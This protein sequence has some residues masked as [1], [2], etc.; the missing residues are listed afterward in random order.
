V[1]N[2][3]G[4]DFRM[5]PDTGA[6]EPVSGLT[7]QG[8]VRDDFGNWFGC[9]NSHL[10]WHY[11]LAD[12]YVRR[13]PFVAAPSPAVPVPRDRD[14]NRVYPA[15]KTLERF[16][17]PQSANRVTSACGLEIYRDEL[18]GRE[19][20]GNAFT[21][22][23][24][25]NLVHRE[26]LIPDG[27]T[28]RS[29][30]ATNEL[31]R[32]F[33]ASTDNLFRPVQARTGPDGA[34]WIVD[35]YRYV[36]EHPRW[37]PSNR[38]AQLDVRAGADKGRIY[39]VYRKDSLPRRIQNYAK[40]ST[41]AL[42]AALDSPNGTERDIIHRELLNREDR[43]VAS[44]LLALSTNSA[45]PV[46]RAQSFS[47]LAAVGAL[48]QPVLEIAFSRERDPW[49]RAHILRLGHDWPCE[50]TVVD[51]V[52]RDSSVLK[53]M[54]DS[55][56]RVRFQAVMSATTN[57]PQWW[58]PSVCAEATTNAWMRAAVLSSV[59]GAA[60]RQLLPSVWQ[61]V[62]PAN[63]Y[64]LPD[65]LFATILADES[66]ETALMTVL[67][68]ANERHPWAFRKTRTVVER[69]RKQLNAGW[70]AAPHTIAEKKETFDKLRRQ[71]SQT[72]RRILRDSALPESLRQEAAKMLAAVFIDSA[73]ESALDSALADSSL[74]DA[75]IEGLIGSDSL[76]FPRFIFT[77]WRELTPAQRMK[78]LNALVTRAS[79]TDALLD[80]IQN[81]VVA[82]QE[83]SLP[84]KSQVLTSKDTGVRARDQRIQNLHPLC[85]C[86]F[87]PAW[88][89][90]TGEF[91]RV[92]AD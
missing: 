48:T 7:Q 4:R 76:E 15:S 27:V 80:A 71:M 87:T 49:V 64:A 34:L 39:R 38:L 82:A 66:I 92:A 30:R 50:R 11:P 33:L 69:W 70:P 86:Q 13:N 63:D 75:A 6:F 32:E 45:R 29:R 54:S 10:L 2:I 5:D 12:E 79:W 14:W 35:M 1:I 44:T 81:R 60:A 68:L 61:Y 83:V 72:S 17:D 23:P 65:G 8:R 37:I 20:Y 91:Q 43:S 77:H 31:N 52:V 56:M 73:D 57:A 19:F 46:V 53:A 3:R 41:S 84:L 9:D 21:C 36:I 67:P 88:K 28:F 47:A 85:R 22:E 58:L 90:E 40:L 55:D 59:D 25:H 16:N 62:E 26:V 74:R 78:I 24:V 42:A 18:L 51:G 89:D